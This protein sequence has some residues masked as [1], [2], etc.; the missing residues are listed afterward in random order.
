MTIHLPDSSST[1]VRRPGPGRTAELHEAPSPMPPGG[2]G[3][4]PPG[5]FAACGLDG[6][7]RNVGQARRFVAHTLDRW[8]LP[9]MAADA[10]LIVSEL[11]TNAVCHAVRHPA[12]P[13]TADAGGTGGTGDA[14]DA[15]DYPV[16]LGLFRDATHLTCAVSDPSSAPPRRPDA[17][18]EAP[19]G[20]GLLLISGLSDTWSWGPTPPRG[21][22]VWASMALPSFAQR[23]GGAPGGV[24]APRPGHGLAG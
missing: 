2:L 20:R 24:P 4:L 16:W 13:E 8:A 21:K 14:G 12:R 6:H 18:T 17:D 9:T 19:G 1:Y 11:V 22:T 5:G 10:Q 23:R 3:D 7:L 15:G